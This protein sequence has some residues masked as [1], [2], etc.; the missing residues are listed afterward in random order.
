MLHS[1]HHMD[2]REK[3]QV[4]QGL[5]FI[6]L[7]FKLM[8]SSDRDWIKYDNLIKRNYNAFYC[9]S[10]WINLTALGYAYFLNDVKACPANYL[11]YWVWQL[12]FWVFFTF[13]EWLS[14]AG[15]ISGHRSTR[16]EKARPPGS[17]RPH[18]G[19]ED[20]PLLSVKAPPG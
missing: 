8:V 11:S 1:C 2:R 3:L 19:P 6:I 18:P 17:Y 15:S 5:G 10:H 4:V 9:I 12:S 20:R 14:Q 16:S 7:G 13:F